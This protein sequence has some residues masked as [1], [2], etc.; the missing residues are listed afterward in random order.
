MASTPNYTDQAASYKS[1]FNAQGRS[2]PGAAVK[3]NEQFDRDNLLHFIEDKFKTNVKGGFKLVNL[4]AFLHTLVK[5]ISVD[6]DDKVGH[7][8]ASSS[9]RISASAADRWYMGSLSY[10]WNYF[11][12]SQYITGTLNSGTTPQIFGTYS[13]MAIDVPFEIF[14][15]RLSGT[16]M[17]QGHTGDVDFIMYYTDQDDS[18]QT[19]LQNPVFICADTVN[20]AVLST[21]YEIN[22]SSAVGFKVP[23]GKKIWLLVR[24]TGGGG[25]TETIKVSWSI[26]YDKRPTNYSL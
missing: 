17:N 9:M 23:Q 13:N 19:Y 26:A 7:I 5:S 1:L 24:N 11:S 15:P 3:S 8:L 21:G 16:V 4:R 6:S 22:A 25:T 20:C 18:S 2:N 12:W 10:G 14:S